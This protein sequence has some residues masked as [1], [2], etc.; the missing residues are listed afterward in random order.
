MQR[1]PKFCL[2]ALIIAA[3][4]VSVA[5]AQSGYALG[6]GVSGDDAGSAALSVFGDYSFTDATSISASYSATN[7]DGDPDDLTTRVWTL[8]VRHDFGPL[9]IDLRGG[10]S[11]DPDDFDS[12]DLRIA[13]FRQTDHWTLNAHGSR[14]DIDLV[15]Q[16][17]NPRLP[18]TRKAS[19][20]GDGLGAR[21]AFRTDSGWRL[22]AGAEVFDYD[23]DLDLLANAAII[24]RLS[25]TTLS[26]SGSLLDQRWSIGIEAPLAK[27]RALSF[28]V[29]RD[30]QVANLG[31]VDSAAI[32]WLT[33]LADR[34]DLDVSLGISQ[35]DSLGDDQTAVFL[36]VLFL[37]YGGF[38]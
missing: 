17:V 22:Y 28:D 14:R 27:Q 20:Q 11:G 33:P 8:G 31:V 6:I 38:D 4:G 10:Q 32:S 18:L 26:L 13:L 2:I 23:R 24:R 25:P 30:T 5:R 19:L 9:G 29:Y 36:S 12:T 34:G 15:F 7:A 21:I 16:G 3:F 35:S 1:N 37:F